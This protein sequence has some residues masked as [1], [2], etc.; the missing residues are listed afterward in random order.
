MTAMVLPPMKSSFEAAARQEARTRAA[1]AAVAIERYRLKNGSVPEKLDQL[2][3]EFLLAVPADPY[4]GQPLRYVTTVA[5][6][7]VYS[8]GAT[9][10]TT[11]GGKTN[12]AATR[13]LPFR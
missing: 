9:A 6:Y 13:T 5:G 4:D 1:A 12:Y 11:A 3:P 8:V 2:V 7:T 10:S